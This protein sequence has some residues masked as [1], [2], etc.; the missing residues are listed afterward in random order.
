MN[1]T[2]H[3]RELIDKFRALASEIAEQDLSH[4]TEEHS[5]TDLGMDSLSM[6]ELVGTLEREYGVRIAEDELAGVT[7]VRQL[8]ELVHD[9]LDAVQA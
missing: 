8:L 6:L 1:G 2:V 9:H 4:V 7:L 3:R 5:I